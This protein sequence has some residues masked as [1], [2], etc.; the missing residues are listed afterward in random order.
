MPERDLG[1][2]F[3]EVYQRDV[4]RPSVVCLCRYGHF[5]GQ[6]GEKVRMVDFQAKS[7]F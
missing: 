3:I 2:K 6:I 1:Q 4:E 5:G 7:V